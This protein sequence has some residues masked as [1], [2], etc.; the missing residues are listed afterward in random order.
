ME[1]ETEKRVVDVV[2]IQAYSLI[3]CGVDLQ[4]W[5]GTW[6]WQDFG[7]GGGRG[8]CRRCRGT[9]VAV[10]GGK[11]VTRTTDI[12]QMTEKI[13][14]YQQ[15]G[16]YPPFE[17]RVSGPNSNFRAKG[18]SWSRIFFFF[19]F[20]HWYFLSNGIQSMHALNYCNRQTG[21]DSSE[22][23]FYTIK[24]SINSCWGIFLLYITLL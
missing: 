4:E 19:W 2:W 9:S 8:Q 10:L 1:R 18:K 7:S 21:M 24:N 17:L 12:R 6:L 5:Q 13:R 20:L 22:V 15:W 14:I 11:P 16:G 23:D 3:C